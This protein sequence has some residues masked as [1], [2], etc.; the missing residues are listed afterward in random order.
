MDRTQQYQVEAERVKERRDPREAW[1]NFL[2]NLEHGCSCNHLE[3]IRRRR[4]VPRISEL[5]QRSNQFNLTT[6]RYSE[7]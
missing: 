7:S 6:I 1:T 3:S 2:A 4:D 5:Y